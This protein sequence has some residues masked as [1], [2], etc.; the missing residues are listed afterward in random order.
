MIQH[1]R[2]F[3]F[4]P[5]CAVVLLPPLAG[6]ELSLEIEPAQSK[7]EFTLGATLHTVHGTFQ[8]KRGSLHFEPASGAASGELLVDARSGAS[9]NDTRD[10]KMH[11]E[12]LESERFPDIVFRPDHAAGKLM[13]QGIS[14]MQVHGAFA[15]H[16]AEHELTTPVEVRVNGSRY[17][18]TARFTVPYL[19]WGIKNPS[20]LFLRVDDHVEIALDAVAHLANPLPSH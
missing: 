18:I 15:I 2:S 3:L 6:Q 7:V 5:L 14:Q 12:I 8:L 19:K 11:K 17:V 1:S 4:L 10:R 16:G 9:G 13:P 20:T